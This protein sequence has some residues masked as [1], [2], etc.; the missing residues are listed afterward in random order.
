MLRRIKEVIDN[1]TATLIVYGWEFLFGLLLLFFIIV[2]KKWLLLIVLSVFL[3]PVPKFIFVCAKCFKVVFSQDFVRLERYTFYRWGEARSGKT[4]TGV[5]E[6]WYTAAALWEDVNE[7]HFLWSKLVLL[8]KYASDTLFLKRYN[9]VNR[10]FEF[11]NAHPDL[12]PCL[13]SNVKIYDKYGR[14]SLDLTRRHVEQEAWL[15]S[16]CAILTD[17]LGSWVLLD[18]S[19]VGQKPMK[20]FNFWRW[21]GQFG[22]FHIISTGQRPNDCPIDIR[23]VIGTFERIVDRRVI[24]RSRTLELLSDVLINVGI[25]F[26]L[27]PKYFGFCKRFKDFVE[28]VGFLRFEIEEQGNMEFGGKSAE[29]NVYETPRKL[30]FKYDSRSYSEIYLAKNKPDENVSSNSMTIE[31]DSEF[32]Q[33]IFKTY[34][35]EELVEK[36]KALSDEEASELELKKYRKKYVPSFV[37]NRKRG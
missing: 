30:P 1:N 27:S 15:P 20:L 12:I 32:A 13:A 26:D 5:A 36:A 35:D 2:S 17:E 22:E 19:R 24:F 37:K 14:R 16:Y 11:W 34:G 9:E 25:K 3:I 21:T 6:A 28:S 31:I 10:T 8:P 4:L 18:E 23:G 29:I 33:A 7:K